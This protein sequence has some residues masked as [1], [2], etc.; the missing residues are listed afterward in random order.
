VTLSRT[1]GG[2]TISLMRKGLVFS[3]AVLA[4]VA[5]LLSWRLYAFLTTST[6]L[7]SSSVLV[8][9]RQGE[10][11]QT[12]AQRFASAG[13][14]T[15]A[16]LFVW[17]SRV[18]GRDRRIKSGEYEFTTPLSPL[19]LLQILTKGEGL[20]HA[21]TITE[22]MT[23]KE[24]ASLL[25]KKGFGSEES[26]LCLNNDPDFLAAWGLP[27]E[28]MEGYLYPDTY[29]FSW[30][31]SAE[32]ILGRMIL[33]LYKAV[34]PEMYR[35]ADAQGQSLHQ[36]LTLASLIE[37]ETG[38]AEERP[39]VAAVFHNRLQQGMPLQCDPSVIYGLAEFDGNLT[40]QHLQTPSPYNTYLIRGLPPGPIAS[41]GIESIRA[42]LNPAQND[43]LY[44]VARGDGSH[45]F[46]SN[47]ATHNQAV[48]R[49]QQRRS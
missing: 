30:L 48:L 21:V 44:F 5:I 20:R 22:G 19:A 34:S 24:V 6:A 29:H 9:V 23:L 47:L 43:Y 15:N 45:V 1:W 39:L 10:S 14:I 35:Q 36:T 16:T 40:R 8:F 3:V 25:A 28:G 41:P 13:V 26:F 2:G 4:C 38:V 37:K 32:E 33:R 31:T 17:W 42:A 18:V 7:P 46:S 49:F 27:P 12:I 11:L